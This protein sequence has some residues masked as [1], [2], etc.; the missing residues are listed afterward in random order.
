MITAEEAKKLTLTTLTH[1]E[2]ISLMEELTTLIKKAC[3]R[4][5]RYINYVYKDYRYKSY[6]AENVPKY[7]FKCEKSLSVFSAIQISW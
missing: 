7:G 4:G 2:V 5:D 1:A 3:N 6:I